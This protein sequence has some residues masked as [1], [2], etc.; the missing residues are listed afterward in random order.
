MP[1]MN[2][3]ARGAL[4]PDFSIFNFLFLVPNVPSKFV[5]GFT[6]KSSQR[7]GLFSDD[8]LTHPFLSFPAMLPD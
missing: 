1:C 5:S 6:M 8:W 2:K 4:V 7:A 3:Y